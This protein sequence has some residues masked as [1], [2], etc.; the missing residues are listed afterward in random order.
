MG[1]VSRRPLMLVIR[2]HLRSGRVNVSR[3][4]TSRA[5]LIQTPRLLFAWEYIS[6]RM[7]VQFFDKAADLAS[8]EVQVTSA[9][10]VN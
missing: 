9:D 7:L 4:V 8:L 6:P 3:I 2:L 5:A 10:L 1:H